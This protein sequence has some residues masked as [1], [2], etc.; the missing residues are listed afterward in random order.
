MHCSAH[1]CKNI[2]KGPTKSFIFARKGEI[3]IW[4]GSSASIKEEMRA[5]VINLMFL[6]N[7]VN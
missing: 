7:I 2:N 5:S 6:T 4:F 3:T 1:H